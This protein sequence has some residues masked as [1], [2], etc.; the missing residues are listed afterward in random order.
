ML[1]LIRI[2]MI[3]MFELIV[4]VVFFAFSRFFFIL[5]SSKDNN[6]NNSNKN[7]EQKRQDEDDRGERKG[8]ENIY[9]RIFTCSERYFFVRDIQVEKEKKYI[10]YTLIVLIICFA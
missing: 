5:C 6:N 9:K 2:K 3:N 8:K 10:T 1:D 4:C 7:K